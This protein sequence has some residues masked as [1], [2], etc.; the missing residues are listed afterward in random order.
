ME[1]VIVGIVILIIIG[2]FGICCK[3]CCIFLKWEDD[4]DDNE[5]I[6]LNNWKLYFKKRLFF[7]SNF[8]WLVYW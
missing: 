5:D 7:M 8:V 3:K 6:N 4:D 2:V 1:Y